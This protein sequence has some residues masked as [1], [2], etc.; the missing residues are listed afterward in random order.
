[1]GK[2]REEAIAR[3]RR[4]RDRRRE[5]AKLRALFGI[6]IQGVFRDLMETAQ[7]SLRRRRV[8]RDRA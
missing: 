3:L 8:E 7:R 2:R 5:R 4:M 1:M 6:E